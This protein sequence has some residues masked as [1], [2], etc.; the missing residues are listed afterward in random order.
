MNTNFNKNLPNGHRFLTNFDK[1]D[2]ER[3]KEAIKV[4]SDLYITDDAYDVFGNQLTDMHRLVSRSS[5]LDYDDFWT[6]LRG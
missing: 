1:R 2:L 6:K 4:D 5:R 3:Y